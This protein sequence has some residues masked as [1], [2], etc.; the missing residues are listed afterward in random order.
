MVL[1]EKLRWLGMNFEAEFSQN[2]YLQRREKSRAQY[3][4]AKDCS[5][6]TAAPG[7]PAP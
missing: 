6:D 1:E 5:P 2:L 4:G 7:L 3:K